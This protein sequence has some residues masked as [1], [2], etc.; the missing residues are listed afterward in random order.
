MKKYDLIIIGG[1][2]ASNLAVAA[3]AAGKNVALLEKDQLGGTCPN[4]GCV[5][6]KLL[7]GYADT[8]RRIREADRHFI[9]ASINAIDLNRIFSETG[10]WLSAVDGRYESRLPDGVDLYRGQASFLDNHTIVTG[11][12]KLTAPQIIIA[13]GTRPRPV[14]E[15]ESDLPIWTSD[16]LFPLTS[17]PPK[18]ITIVGGGFIAVELANFFE[19]IGVK[20]CLLVRGNRLLP[21]ED[22]E[23][24]DIF[25]KEF[26]KNVDTR[27]NTSIQSTNY[28]H[29]QFSLELSD[30]STHHSEAL[31]YA[32]GRISN[33]DTLNLQNTDIKTDSKGYITRN[34]HLESS[35]PGIYVVGDAAGQHQLQ[36][37]AAY[38]VHYL[39]QKLLKNNP[40]PISYGQMPHAVFS[41]PEIASVGLTEEQAKAQGLPYVTVTED[42]LASARAM[43]TRLTY[44]RTKMIVHSKSY[45]ILGCHL[46]GPES[47][48]MLHQVMMLMHLKN[49]IRELP[50]MIHIHPALPEALLS[51]SISAIKKIKTLTNSHS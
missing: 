34:D 45:E 2:R 26:S 42:W 37:A 4:R 33:A 1:G 48:T 24:S 13:T 3:A 12:E 5:P 10:E 9:N 19:A 36:H 8:A 49:D 35:V 15:N 23:I 44:P 39:R 29:Q 11:D 20:T 21:A 38:D 31:L 25:L 41:E 43:S 22:A 47:S 32:I 51:A 30:G 16:D 50:K 7:I 17:P 46:I 28:N 6:S 18:S 40:D 27:L 14:P